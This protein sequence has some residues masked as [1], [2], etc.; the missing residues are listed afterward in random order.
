[1]GDSSH[2]HHLHLYGLEKISGHRDVEAHAFSNG[3]YKVRIEP[4]D[5][6]DHSHDEPT[7]HSYVMKT[8]AI[9]KRDEY[10][11]GS[12]DTV[13]KKGREKWMKIEDKADEINE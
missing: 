9:Q 13:K 6:K 4:H 1:M 12:E 7:E 10:G 5:G 11:L 3:R 2:L 8:D